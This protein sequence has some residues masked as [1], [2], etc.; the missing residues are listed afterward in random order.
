MQESRN[1][2]EST[3]LWMAKATSGVLIV[4]ILIVH[5][6]ANHLAPGGLKNYADVVAYL[7]NPWIALLEE[8]FLVLVVSHALLGMRGIVLDLNPSYPLMRWVD[9]ALWA[10]AILAVIYGIWLIRVIVSRGTGG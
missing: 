8:T 6:A 10:T 1:P 5:L 2:R 4:V 3:W 7:S 9:R